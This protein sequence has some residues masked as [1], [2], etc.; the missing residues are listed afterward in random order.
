[1]TIL[2]DLVDSYVVRPL[3]ELIQTSPSCRREARYGYVSLHRYAR[4]F[5]LLDRPV[6]GT[7]RRM[8]GEWCDGRGD[9]PEGGGGVVALGR[10]FFSSR[11]RHTRFD[12]DWSSDVCSSD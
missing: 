9:L 7:I 1:M 12:C 8:K 3:R 11:R 4:C 2:A 5:R 6:E 10:F